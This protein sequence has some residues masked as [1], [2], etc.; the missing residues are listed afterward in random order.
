MQKINIAKMI[1][2]IRELNIVNTLFIC[3]NIIIIQKFKK[4]LKLN[5]F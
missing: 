4:L 5:N 2:L 3:K 1:I